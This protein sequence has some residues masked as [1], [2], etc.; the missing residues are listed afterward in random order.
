M[1]IDFSFPPEIESL[2]LKVREFV[3]TVVRRRIAHRAIDAYK[4]HGTTKAATGGLPL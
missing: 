1:A 3:E 2:R 4:K